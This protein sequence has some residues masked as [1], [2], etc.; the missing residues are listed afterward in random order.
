MNM[1]FN[2]RTS[3][4]SQGTTTK[5]VR[6]AGGLGTERVLGGADTGGAFGVVL[7]DL[8]PKQLGSPIHTH[9]NEDEYSYVLSGRL[10]AL[11][12]DEIVE[13]GPGEAVVKPRGIPHAFWNAGDEELR[14]VEIISP[15]GFEDYFFELAEPLNSG[16][17]EAIGAILAR[18]ELDLRMET[19]P[20][21]VERNG[22]VPPW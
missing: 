20:E 13:A 17:G 14:F 6:F 22:L 5:H 2:E 4:M 7:H 18:Y 15:S 12:G 10:T 21:L 1:V 9:A 16:D 8:P 11:I 3:E 19:V